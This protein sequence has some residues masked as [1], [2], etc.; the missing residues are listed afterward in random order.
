MKFYTIVIIWR[1]SVGLGNWER[2]REIPDLMELHH[3]I[4]KQK[5]KQKKNAKN[6]S[7]YLVLEHI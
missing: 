6:R 4:K 2:D 5:Q 7:R 3:K 1:K